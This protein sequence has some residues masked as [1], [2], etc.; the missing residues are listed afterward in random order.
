MVA[1][2]DLRAQLVELVCGPEVLK[3]LAEPVKLSSGQWSDVFIDAKVAVSTADALE[4]VG[5]AMSEAAS[6]VGAAFDAVGGL[7]LGAVPFTFAVAA[8][9]RSKWFLVRKQPKGRGTNRWV[10]GTRLEPGMPVMLVDDVVTTGGS[11]VTAYERAREEGAE[12]VFASTLVDRGDEASQFF[13]R[14][15]V[16]YQPMLTYADLGIDPVRPPQ[17]AGA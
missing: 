6:E 17:P 2:A 1:V 10:E 7:E 5:R 12:V 4:L 15:R 8:A 14:Q 3:R 16:P 11:I 9:A 13:A